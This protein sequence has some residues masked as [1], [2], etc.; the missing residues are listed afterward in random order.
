MSNK[1]ERWHFK[2]DL[3]KQVSPYY[4]WPPKFRESLL[5][6]FKAW[7]PLDVR[8]WVLL[9]S[10]SIWMLFYPEIESCAVIGW[11]C[12]LP[13]WIRNVL[14]LLV[15]AG[16]LHLYFYTYNRQKTE[17]KYEARFLDPA[18][19]RFHFNSQLADNV[20]WVLIGTAG[21]L[22]FYEV[23]MMWFYANE[24]PA[25]IKFA[26]SPFWFLSVFLLVPGWTSFHFYWQH[27]AFHSPVLY[28]LGHDWHHRNVNVGP[29]SG[30]AV[31]PFEG[32]VW[33]SAVL[34]LLFVPSHP[35]H[36]IFLMQLQVI[37]AV[38][39]HVGFENARLP[40]GLGFRLGDFYHQLHHRFFE[41]NYGTMSA[42]WDRWFGT[43]HDGSQSGD[44]QVAK[45]RNHSVVRS[46]D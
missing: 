12:V 41:C 5:C 38:T 10:I 34:L 4:Q 20:F 43:Y 42:P 40:G 18:S 15:V 19:S 33:F 7:S 13:I 29:W 26:D 25:P 37:T 35:M 24:N 39:T 32:F 45:R 28:K 30:A 36:A 2:P 1:R 27:R 46:D 44:R 17:E 3:N 23:L 6:M 31:H 9:F 11:S 22:T 16:G 8:I 14:T 21:M